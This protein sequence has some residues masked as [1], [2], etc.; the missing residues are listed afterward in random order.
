MSMKMGTVPKFIK[1]RKRG[2]VTDNK[3]GAD[4]LLR[5][6][7]RLIVRRSPPGTICPP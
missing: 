6:V 1:E 7:A 5:S 3:L 2:K 4:G